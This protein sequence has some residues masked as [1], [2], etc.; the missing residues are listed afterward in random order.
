M[1]MT[2]R[3][4]PKVVW[5]SALGCAL[6]SA[7]VHVPE[8]TL[9]DA[10]A[11]PAREGGADS[12]SDTTPSHTS[13]SDTKPSAAGR[14][15]RE[16]FAD[17]PLLYL[18]TSALKGN[19]DLLIT[20]QRV[21][22][23][24]ANV[25][26]A[27][28]AVWPKVGLAAGAGVRRFGDYT[29]DGAGNA[30]T[31][32]T[33]G[34]RV[35]EHLPDLSVGLR[36]SWE[37]DVWGRL[38]N[39]RDAATA[40]YLATLEGKNLLTTT[41]VAEV[42]SAYFELV[43]LDHQRA[44]LSQTVA[45][46]EQALAIVR[47]QKQV[48]RA[49]ELAVQ[50]FEAQLAS[51]QALEVAA[52]EGI[53]VLENQLNLLLGRLPQPLARTDDAG[54]AP[55][56][57]DVSA[58]VPSE[59]L[60]H[61]PDIRRAELEVQAA[62]FDV[63]AARAAFFP[64]LTISAG[65]GFQA[66]NPRYLF[67]TPASVTYSAFAGLLAPLVNR[68]G[69]EAD[70]AAAKAQQIQAMYEYQKAILTGFIE[71]ANGLTAIERSARAVDFRRAQRAAAV[72]TVEAADALYRAGKATYFEV[73]IAQQNTLAAELELIEASKRQR[74]ASVGLYRALGGGWQ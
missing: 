73:L 69:I 6:P 27:T 11:G 12:P 10:Y 70:F 64:R 9:P 7:E 42:A 51:T 59:L 36:S 40:S 74:L 63:E 53:Q 18:I 29:M 30:A 67:S 4:L 5:L 66:F 71:V 2:P 13:P 19:P 52:L 14:S 50:Q 55:V 24:R 48:G 15:W 65:V 28:G 33:P 34:E 3:F 56:G 47:L 43:A 26:R 37:I 44:V 20:L 62:K 68:S 60:R 54:L 45:R 17:P 8:L 21:E 38:R 41:L 72:G 58:G 35:P 25:Q 16:Y 31:E 61:R 32:I 1:S 46:Q 23:A 22:V 39:Q 49:N 57:R